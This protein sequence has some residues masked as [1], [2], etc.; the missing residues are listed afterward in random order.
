MTPIET[1]PY[2]EVT[3]PD[4]YTDSGYRP[5]S[6]QRGWEIHQSGEVKYTSPSRQQGP[7]RFM[8]P[9][10][11]VV[12]PES[13]PVEEH[14]KALQMLQQWLDSCHG[15]GY[16]SGLPRSQHVAAYIAERRPAA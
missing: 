7:Y 10:V 4:W 15:V 12:V 2:W 3:P 11:S 9:W 5:P 1:R 8:G 13:A 14:H 16:R 6:P